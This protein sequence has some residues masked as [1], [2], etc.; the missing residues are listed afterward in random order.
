MS[1]WQARHLTVQ[2]ASDLHCGDRPLGFVA[3]TLPYVPAHIPW[4]ALVPA[5]VSNLG[6]PDRFASYRRVEDFFQ[7]ALR[8]TPFFPAMGD[9]GESRILPLEAVE[10]NLLASQYGIG[11]C[12]GERGA[13]EGHLYETEVLLARGRDGRPT[14]LH[15]CCFWRPRREDGL[16]LDENGHLNGRPLTELMAQCQ[17]GGQRNK[18]LGRLRA[19]EERPFDPRAGFGRA[20]RA[21]EEW[22]VLIQAAAVPAPFFL[23]YD[24]DLEGRVHG[25][26]APLVG[27]R[28]AEDRGPGLAAEDCAIVWPPGW[29]WQGAADPDGGLALEL[30]DRR[31]V[32]A[33]PA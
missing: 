3:R 32:R 9:G 19:V 28:F 13:P 18:G 4:Y 8:L 29:Q 22:P 24:P 33:L 14:R 7:Q 20:F 23:R 12:Y 15:G 21:A 10:T 11:V 1:N 26:L 25:R 17:W 5:V 2:L 16:E 30:S 31:T 27:R 6:W